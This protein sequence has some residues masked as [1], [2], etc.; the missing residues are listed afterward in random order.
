MCVSP[1][2]PFIPSFSAFF[3]LLLLLK[4]D[5]QKDFSIPS[6][7]HLSARSKY[8]S[9]SPVAVILNIKNDLNTKK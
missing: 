1:P 3:L 2:L 7:K 8:I 4:N 6:D 9:A 5:I